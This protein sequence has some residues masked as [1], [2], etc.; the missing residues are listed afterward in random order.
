M[1][2]LRSVKHRPDTCGCIYEAEGTDPEAFWS[3]AVRDVVPCAAHSHLVEPEDIRDAIKEEMLRK[4]YAIGQV[5]REFM[6]QL[7]SIVDGQPCVQQ[8]HESEAAERQLRGEKVVGWRF[9]AARVVHVTLPPFLAYSIDS[10]DHAQAQCDAR[11]GAGKVVV[12]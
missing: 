9:D 3:W 4:N 1:S 2:A 5:L 8:A 10:L 7:L 12:G 11:F 6:P